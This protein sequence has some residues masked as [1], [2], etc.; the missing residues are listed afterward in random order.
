VEKEKLQEIWG[1]Q[2]KDLRKA[3][4]AKMFEYS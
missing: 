1:I 4:L 2:R 3:L